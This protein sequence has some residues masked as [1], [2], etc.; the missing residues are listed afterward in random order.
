M[1]V[2]KWS[3]QKRGLDSTNAAIRGDMVITMH[4]G[5]LQH[6]DPKRRTE[7]YREFIRLIDNLK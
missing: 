7:N 3:F 5:N 4:L 2:S 6:P 1:K